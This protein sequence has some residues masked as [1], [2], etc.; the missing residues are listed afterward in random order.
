MRIEAAYDIAF[1]CPQE[2]VMVLML[3]VHPSRQ[4]DPLT[5]HRITLLA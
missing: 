1:N 5:E 4:E 2:V 3:S